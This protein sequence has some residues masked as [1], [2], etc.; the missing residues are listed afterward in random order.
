MGLPIAALV[1]VIVLLLVL[2]TTD[3]NISQSRRIEKQVERDRRR[4]RTKTLQGWSPERIAKRYPSLAPDHIRQVRRQVA[5]HLEAS[6]EVQ[7][8]KTLWEASES[9]PS[10][11]Q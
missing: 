7:V 8:L 11:E 10:R 9:E 6:Q 3:L 5:R 2:M 1:S 4:I